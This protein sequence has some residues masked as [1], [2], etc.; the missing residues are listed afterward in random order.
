[1]NLRNRFSCDSY[2][3]FGIE[4][5]VSH[6]KKERNGGKEGR[7]GIRIL[8]ESWL[9]STVCSLCH[10]HPLPVLNEEVA[11]TPKK[12]GLWQCIAP[13]CLAFS[14]AQA[15]FPREQLPKSRRKD[16]CADH[17]GSEERRELGMDA[18][19]HPD[20]RRGEGTP[21][22]WQERWSLG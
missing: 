21:A 18:F 4:E 17:K 13:P 14:L 1:M 10:P 16:L 8:G 7:T 5:L 2:L 22:E 9:F 11:A 19:L 12:E 3:E 6:N 15:C 20:H